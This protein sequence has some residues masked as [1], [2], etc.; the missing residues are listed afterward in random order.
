M[1]VI[2]RLLSLSGNSS[3][4]EEASSV[5][6]PRHYSE[7]DFALT[8]L[9]ELLAEKEI[10]VHNLR[11]ESKELKER[12]ANMETQVHS[13]ENESKER[14]R[15]VNELNE[16]L[17]EKNTINK[18]LAV[19]VE[20]YERTIASLIAG[21]EQDRKRNAEERKRIISERDEQ[22]A[23]LASMEVS[24]R[25]LHSK[26]EKS[27]QIILNMKANEDKYKASL[28]TFEDNL[29]KMQNN[30]E[31][32]K[33][34]ATSKLNH[35]N[36]ELE[37]YNRS[38]EAEVLKLNA[39]IK[40][41]ELHITSL[42]ESLSQKTK[43]NEEL[44]AICDELINKII[45]LSNCDTLATHHRDAPT[46]VPHSASLIRTPHLRCI[47]LTFA[48]ILPGLVI[49]SSVAMTTKDKQHKLCQ[50]VALNTELESIPG[51]EVQG[52]YDETVEVNAKEIESPPTSDEESIKAMSKFKP[53]VRHTARHDFDSDSESDSSPDKFDNLTEEDESPERKSDIEDAKKKVKSSSDLSRQSSNQHNSSHSESDSAD[54][55]LEQ[56]EASSGKKRGVVIPA[57]GAYDPK[58]YADLKVPPE[59]DNVY[60]PQ[61]I[62]ID[63]KLH[64][65]IPEYV[66]AV[67]DADAFLKVTTPASGLRGKALADNALDFIDNLGLTV[68]D[69]PSADQSDA[70]LLHLQL[71]AISKTTSAKST[72]MTRKLENAENNP[73]ALDRWIRD[74]SALHAGRS[75]ATVAYTRKMPDID[76]LMAEWPDAI[77]DTLNEVGVPPASVDCSLSQYVDIVCAVFDIPVH[78]D[79]VNDR[80][81]ALHLLFSLYSAVK[82]SQL[83]A[84]REKEKGMAG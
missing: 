18:S 63:F 77:E 35:A 13:L 66:P 3:R 73:Q 51:L 17:A 62:D 21:M 84:E 38:H 78:G 14:L 12:L 80:I 58:A 70:A 25:D 9:R 28:K 79:T 69:E 56:V 16:R 50:T 6:L 19:V 43:A 83:F 37:K 82:N 30:Y 7:T 40:R 61:K 20:E 81:Q 27:K 48:A 55:G 23:H 1:A 34:H 76:D 42:E 31:L 59:L 72:V 53:P 71:R 8:Q 29:L 26:Y 46:P 32:L 36:Q 74:V 4:L 75:R 5:P 52:M 33:Q 67:G 57:E 45:V 44:T 2:D 11:L 47:F 60:T 49:H 68:L 39:M 54:V 15:K 22:T 65:F 64:P 41:K 24:F 10:N